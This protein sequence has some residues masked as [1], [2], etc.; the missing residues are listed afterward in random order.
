MTTISIEENVRVEFDRFYLS[1][2]LYDI[3]LPKELQVLLGKLEEDVIQPYSRQLSKSYDEG[4]ETGF[5]EG[6][7]SA[8]DDGFSSGE[9][10]GY[11][12]GY[13]DGLAKS[14]KES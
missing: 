4:Y 6:E 11:E 13:Q 10:Y 8:Y 2:K 1:C 12:G 7:L 5:D 14:K 3:E 9:V